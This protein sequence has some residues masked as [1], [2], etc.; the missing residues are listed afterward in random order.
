MQLDE[1]R[2]ESERR[3]ETREQHEPKGIFVQGGLP[4]TAANKENGMITCA[5]EAAAAAAAKKPRCSARQ[6][7]EAGARRINECPHSARLIKILTGAAGG[8]DDF[9]RAHF[10]GCA[11]CQ[12]VFRRA[13]PGR[14]G[15]A[16]FRQAE[17]QLG[18]AA[19]S[20][21]CPAIEELA[22]YAVWPQLDAILP[23]RLD[24]D[25]RA[26]IKAHLEQGCPACRKQVEI[27]QRRA[28]R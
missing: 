5:A 28:R 20:E 24:D 4:R 10:A 17:Q 13:M 8:L 27:A 1:L 11:K 12:T 18:L 9:L 16:E 19:R 7:Q 15:E 23:D 21:S 6:K 25:R 22:N 26:E 2:S 14:I 3:L